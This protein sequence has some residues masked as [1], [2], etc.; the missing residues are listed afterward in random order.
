MTPDAGAAADLQHS[1][2]TRFPSLPRPAAVPSAAGR[3]LREA[4]EVISF[5]AGMTVFGLIAAFFLVMHS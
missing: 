1:D 2:E 5:A 3:F 4:V